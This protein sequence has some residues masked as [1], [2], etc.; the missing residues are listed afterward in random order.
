VNGS[1][2]SR[3]G[4]DVKYLP[5][6]DNAV[7]LTIKPD[8]S[9]VES[10]TAQIATNQR[11]ALFYPERRPFFLEGLDLFATPFQA[12]YT[13]TITAPTAGG[14]LTGKAAGTRYTVLVADDSGGGSAV[15]PG[16]A[17]SSLASVDF[18]STVFVA[19]AKRDLG[20]SFVSVLATDREHRDGQ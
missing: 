14:R 15:L 4:L 12:V 8:F 7:D 18:G 19:R 17:S 10:D 1:V 20:L 13:R 16:P 11:F 2:R 6:A 5:N 3:V 9:Q